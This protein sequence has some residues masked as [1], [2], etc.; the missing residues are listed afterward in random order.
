MA[1]PVSRRPRQSAASQYHTESESP[2]DRRRQAAL[3]QGDLR[4]RTLQSPG[5]AAASTPVAAGD[6]RSNFASKSPGPGDWSLGGD[7]GYGGLGASRTRSPRSGYP[8]KPWRP[9]GDWGTALGRRV[10]GRPSFLESEVEGRWRRVRPQELLALLLAVLFLA[11]LA[12]SAL[13]LYR[14]WPAPAPSPSAPP[15]VVD[16]GASG[17]VDGEEGR[18]GG[19]QLKDFLGGGKQGE[20]G[21]GALPLSQAG[22]EGSDVESEEDASDPEENSEDSEK[23]M[24]VKQLQE[25]LEQSRRQ[26]EIVNMEKEIVMRRSKLLRKIKSFGPPSVPNAKTFDTDVEMKNIEQKSEVGFGK[27]KELEAPVKEVRSETVEKVKPT[28]KRSKAVNPLVKK[29]QMRMSKV[30]GQRSGL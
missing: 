26:L 21:P 24:K 16:S 18:Q 13:I 1:S 17:L 29:Q 4:R 19:E 23:S 7:S 25:E 10:W 6:W 28:R 22:G 3:H 5:P 30:M 2:G 20:G 9:L 14:H 27:T 15:L 12:L 8:S 11:A